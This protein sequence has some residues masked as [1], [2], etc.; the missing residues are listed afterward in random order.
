MPLNYIRIL[1]TL[2][3]LVIQ[4]HCLQHYTFICV[5]IP[6]LKIK[7]VDSILV[8]LNL[9]VRTKLSFTLVRT[10]PTIRPVT[11]TLRRPQKNQ[12]TASNE[13]TR[14]PY[15]FDKIWSGAPNGCSGILFLIRNA[16][17]FDKSPNSMHFK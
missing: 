8:Y 3:N 10:R 17:N 5:V 2:A 12:D 15:N 9:K 16:N 7:Y 6:L 1:T 13:Q 11:A 14:K 4:L